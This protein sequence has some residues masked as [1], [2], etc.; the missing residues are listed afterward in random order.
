MAPVCPPLYLQGLLEELLCILTA[1]ADGFPRRAAMQV[2]TQWVQDGHATVATQ[3]EP[4]VARALQ[5][6]G[7]DLDW[8]VR[9][10]G[11]ELAQVF[12]SQILGLPVAPCPYAPALPAV[13]PQQLLAQALETLCRVRLFDFAFRALFDCDRPVARKS[14]A[15]LLFLR[16][17]TAPEAMD[18]P[19]SANIDA[20]LQRWQVGEQG[21]PQ[22]NLEPEAVGDALEP[23]AALAVL[24]ALD[25]EQLRDVLA[26]SSDHI[27]KSGQSL[28]QDMLAS[29]GTTGENE[30]DCY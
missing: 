20:T 24:W 7:R 30:A 18:C 14:C 28:L 22:G 26:L 5:A 4:L 17:H 27:E 21:Q 16:N 10:Q 15:L 1:D 11:V 9:A 2:L 6:A 19:A 25:L 13:A 29:A 12:L 3:L 8:E 23:K